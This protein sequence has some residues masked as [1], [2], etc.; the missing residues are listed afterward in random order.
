[1]KVFSSILLLYVVTALMASQLFAQSDPCVNGLRDANQLTEKGKYDEAIVLLKSI[2]KSCDQGKNDKIQ[3][4]KLLIINYLAIDNLEEAENVANTI[5]KID[6]N[7]ECDKLRDEPE[8]IA[9]FQKYK[10]AIV[11]KGIV[12]TGLN[13]SRASASETFSI[14]AN[15][16]SSDLDNY[17]SVAGFQIA[18]GLEYK[19]F[20]SLWIQPSFMFRNAGYSIDIP[21]VQ[22]RTIRYKETINYFD[23]PVVAK[24]Y[25]LKS[26]F[27]PFLQAGANFS[28]INSALGELSRDE[29]SDIINR[30]PQRNDFQLGY[31]AGAGFAYEFKEWSIQ[32]G[33]NYLWNPLNLNKEG[34][35][36]DNSDAV[37]KY[38]YLDN[39]FVLNNVNVYVGL[40][41]ALAY[42]NVL[43]KKEK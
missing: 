8:I 35:R 33:V 20:K 19:L 30:K 17:E 5:L 38:Y 9:L 34:T 24:Y 15:N 2:L 37:F 23:F 21:N 32:A 42:R 3:S 25:L 13:F 6:P 40:S 16:N 22:G 7:F 28:F 10:P 31:I 43:S 4:N 11:M 41:Y 36:Y 27:K 1:M 12:L 29:E 39:D 26:N 14:V 18:L